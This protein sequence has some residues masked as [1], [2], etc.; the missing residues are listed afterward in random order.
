MEYPVTY[1]S[2]ENMDTFEDESSAKADRHKSGYNGMVKLN[3]N[4][5]KHFFTPVSLLPIVQGT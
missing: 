2:D 1:L 3:F 4:Q 5:V